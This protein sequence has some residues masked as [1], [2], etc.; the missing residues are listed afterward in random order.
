MCRMWYI[1]MAIQKL[2]TGNNRKKCNGECCHFHLLTGTYIPAGNHS[3]KS[4]TGIINMDNATNISFDGKPIC[5]YA[6]SI[7]YTT[8]MAIISLVAL[9]GNIQVI[10]TAYNTPSLRTSTNHC[11]NMAVS[12]FLS[13]VTIWPLHL[14]DKTITYHGSLLQGSGVYWM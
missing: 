1:C 10:S 13:C 5:R 7:F 9:T 14:N 8:A 11:V 12:D 4:L 3:W 2:T 6:V